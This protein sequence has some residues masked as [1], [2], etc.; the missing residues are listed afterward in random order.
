MHFG[1]LA[2]AC[3]PVHMYY[4]CA[5]LIK[6]IFFLVFFHITD[7]QPYRSSQHMFNESQGSNVPMNN[8]SG[9]VNG[10]ESG[11]TIANNSSN[12]NGVNEGSPAGAGHSMR[13]IVN[14]DQSHNKSE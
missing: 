11:G 6:Y 5:L 9:M 1:Y 4:L 7:E 3:V 12:S 8:S 2:V 14:D 13:T 10:N